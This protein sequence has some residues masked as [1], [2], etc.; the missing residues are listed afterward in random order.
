MV[1]VAT[2]IHMIEFWELFEVWYHFE[3]FVSEF[4]IKNIKSEFS[5]IDFK[6]LMKF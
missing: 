3:I 5:Y 2:R 1:A 4:D 6:P